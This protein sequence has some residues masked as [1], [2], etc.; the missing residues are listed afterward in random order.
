MI[1]PGH[2]IDVDGPVATVT[3]LRRRLDWA[4][5]AELT[6]AALALTHLPG[7]RA[8]VLAS[9]GADFSHGAD[10]ADPGLAG[11]LRED[12]G[13]RV[14]AR[15]ARLLATWSALP[16]PTIAVL[17]GRVIGGGVGLALACDLRVAAHGTTLALPEVLRGIHPGWQIIP[18]LVATA[19]LSAARWMLLSGEPVAIEDLP[20]G[21]TLTDDPLARAHALA[22]RL[23]AAS[24][25]AVRHVKETLARCVDLG[26][27]GDDAARFADTVA[28]PDFA[29]AID[30][31]FS[32]RPPRFADP[33]PPEP[34]DDRDP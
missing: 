6:D 20:G 26:P 3:L 4:L 7:V 31:W 25:R 33:Q 1:E 19:G 27:A 32:R 14:A 21:A 12:G 13:H 2:R 5:L 30:A 11:A 16:M 23:A 28:G 15:G 9:E 18:R 10:L 34:T 24:P 29:E 17:R 22:A 8:V